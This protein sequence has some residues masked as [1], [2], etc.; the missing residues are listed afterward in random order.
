MKAEPASEKL[1]NSHGIIA[2]L[3]SSVDGQG[4]HDRGRDSFAKVIQPAGFWLGNRLSEE[5][6]GELI[7]ANP[8]EQWNDFLL[9]R[10]L[11]V[12]SDRECFTT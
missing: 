6:V 9:T 10:L 1:S 7:R 12:M 5:I 11:K 8:P 2:V 4:S 3:A